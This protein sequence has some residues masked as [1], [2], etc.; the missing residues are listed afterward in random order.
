VEKR[1]EQLVQLWYGHWRLWV[2]SNLSSKI[3]AVGFEEI[4]E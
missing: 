3:E 1:G 2:E 4:F